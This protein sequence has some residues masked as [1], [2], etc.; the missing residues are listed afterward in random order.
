MRAGT[1]GHPHEKLLR[2]A[3]VVQV[4]G[5]RGVPDAVDA[6]LRGYERTVRVV[7]HAAVLEPDP[8]RGLAMTGRQVD[9]PD[10]AGHGVGEQ[11][12]TWCEQ[13]APVQPADGMAELQDSL[14]AGRL[15]RCP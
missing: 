14:G 13:A 6:G 8:R 4:V 5:P 12:Y 10:Q 15:A 7:I 9:A 3:G 11:D 2:R 1:D